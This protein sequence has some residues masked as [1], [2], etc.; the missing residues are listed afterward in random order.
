MHGIV[1]I[2]AQV[3]PVGIQFGSQVGKTEVGLR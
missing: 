2:S 3:C 1:D